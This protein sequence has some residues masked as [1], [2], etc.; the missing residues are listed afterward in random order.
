MQLTHPNTLK[1]T[2]SFLLQCPCVV[3][4]IFLGTTVMHGQ[5]NALKYSIFNTKVDIYKKKF[6]YAIRKPN[7]LTAML[8]FYFVKCY[9]PG[10]CI[11]YVDQNRFYVSG[12]FGVIFPES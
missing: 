10:W 6:G 3:L 12:L 1:R 7:L 9:K 8:V 11:L 2:L 5:F 4:N